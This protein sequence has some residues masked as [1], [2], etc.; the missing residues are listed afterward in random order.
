MTTVT[1]G[2]TPPVAS[3]TRPRISP[4]VAWDC[5]KTEPAAR[6]PVKAR[7]AKRALFFTFTLLSGGDFARDSTAA[8]FAEST[9]RFGLGAGVDII[10]V[11]SQEVSP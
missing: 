5:G 3:T 9:L 8:V 4:V 2:R 10:P 11:F 1:P 7:D 6:I